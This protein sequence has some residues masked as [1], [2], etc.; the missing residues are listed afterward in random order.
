MAWPRRI[1]GDHVR[2]GGQPGEHLEHLD[3][4]DDAARRLGADGNARWTAFGP[5]NARLHRVNIAR[6]AAG[7]GAL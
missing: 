4:A 5:T 7:I 3:E 1:D 6:F 2:M